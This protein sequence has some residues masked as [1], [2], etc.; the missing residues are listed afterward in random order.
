METLSLPAAGEDIHT[1]VLGVFFLLFILVGIF[2]GHKIWK[3]PEQIT[4]GNYAF[5][6]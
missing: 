4:G 3:E 2:G 1:I 6:G 5:V